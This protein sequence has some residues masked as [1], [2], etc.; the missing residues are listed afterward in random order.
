MSPAS[1]CPEKK[2][3]PVFCQ[4]GFGGSLH[5]NSRVDYFFFAFFFAG[6]AFALADFLG[7]FLPAAFLAVFAF[8][9]TLAFFGAGLAFFPGL[10]FFA[11]FA[12]LAGLAF[13]ATRFAALTFAAFGFTFALA[14]GLLAGAG[15]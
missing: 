8:E 1:Y 2:A 12:F 15:D 10:V 9:L 7:A 14:L 5:S 13:L 6:F 4:A 11:G 3:C